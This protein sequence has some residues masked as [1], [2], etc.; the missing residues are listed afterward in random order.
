MY[1]VLDLGS[2]S[3]HL[4]IAER[5]NGKVNIVK[6]CNSKVQLGD[7]LNH[8]GKIS[9]EARER[10]L[11]AFKGFRREMSSYSIERFCV[12]GTN[13]F[14]E[15]KN[16]AK[17]MEEANA[18]GFPINVISGLQ[19]AFYIYQGVNS[20]LLPAEEPRLIIDIGGGSTE[21]AVGMT[22]VPL[23][24]D[25]LPIGCV[26][27]RS[28]E[29]SEKGEEKITRKSLAKLR[30][31]IHEILDE[32]LNQQFYE[33]DW[34]ECYASSGTAKMLSGVLRENKLSDGT[35]T[36]T[37]LKQ[38][39][40]L[41]IDLGSTAELEKL[42]GLKANRRNVFTCGLS[43]MQSIMDHL[44]LEHIEYSDYALRE[45]VLLGLVRQGESFPLYTLK[46]EEA[47][48]PRLL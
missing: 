39:E 15:A 18:L 2:N 1:A 22:D 5:K 6:T 9:K 29:L 37:A 35:I 31:Q 23:L 36:E 25:S 3:F 17:L 4:V 48:T 14:R 7:G 42:P 44:G 40:A 8:T 47:H 45:G 28:A 46:G 38:L 10:A 21:F 43:I 30:R 11:E 41:A 27:A 19:E 24:L 12:V 34:H 13:T 16:A 20:F 33:M 26:T 32:G